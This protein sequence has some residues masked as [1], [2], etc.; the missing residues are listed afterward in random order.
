MIHTQ[1][2]CCAVLPAQIDE[3]Y[4]FVVDALQFGSIFLVGIGK[5]LELACG[6]NEIAWIDAHLVGYL[7][8]RH[9]R[10]WIE[11]NI[12]NQWNLAATLAH[13]LSYDAQVL[14]FSHPLSGETNIM[15]T[16]IGDAHYLLHASLNIIG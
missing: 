8:C 7:C 11:V 14:G 12:G 5:A 4:K 2:H 3:G 1:A 13:L 9:C 15:R 16:C 6:I 10:T